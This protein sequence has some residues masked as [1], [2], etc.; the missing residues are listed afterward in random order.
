MLVH[1]HWGAEL[2]HLRYG[3]RPKVLPQLSVP[4]PVAQGSQT[5]FTPRRPV[6]FGIFGGL[7]GYK[8]IMEALESFFIARRTHPQ[9]RLIIAGRSDD[10]GIVGQ[11][12]KRLSQLDRSE[13]IGCDT[14]T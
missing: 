9:M 13:Q 10:I 6:T 2:I 12:Q 8:R 1:S 11:V 3:V 14:V 7:S 4:V 5:D